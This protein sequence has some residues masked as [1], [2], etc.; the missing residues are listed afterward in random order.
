MKLCGVCDVISM[1]SE[2]PTKIKHYWTI[3][4]METLEILFEGEH[5]TLDVDDPTKD[6]NSREVRIA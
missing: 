2:R 5:V 6:S 1:C 4:R 3:V